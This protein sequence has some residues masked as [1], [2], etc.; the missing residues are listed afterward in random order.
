M[1]LINQLLD[2]VLRRII[3]YDR[4]IKISMLVEVQGTLDSSNDPISFVAK[5][6]AAEKRKKQSN[7]LRVLLISIHSLET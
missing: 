6:S 7:W 4:D 3:A 2:V 1:C 5:R